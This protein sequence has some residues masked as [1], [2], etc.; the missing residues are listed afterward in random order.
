MHTKIYSL[1]T[2]TGNIE[3]RSRSQNNVKIDMKKRGWKGV[4]RT[5]PAQ[6]K[7]QGFVNLVL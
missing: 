5:Q 1:N 7:D 4:K 2:K 6:Y 3:D